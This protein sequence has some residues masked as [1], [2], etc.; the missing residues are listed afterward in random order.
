MYVKPKTLSIL[1]V[2]HLPLPWPGERLQK[3]F[4]DLRYKSGSVG[5]GAASG[6]SAGLYRKGITEHSQ[7]HGSG[8]CTKSGS[9]LERNSVRAGRT[10]ES[11]DRRQG[12]E[13][14]LRCDETGTC[15]H[16]GAMGKTKGSEDCLNLDIFHP[17]TKEKICPSCSLSMVVIIRAVLLTK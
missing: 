6:E 10:L 1:L 4:P 12:L 11:S 5:K 7:R 3:C 8:I 13:W 16:S 9:N 14:H 17:N 15:C 2:P